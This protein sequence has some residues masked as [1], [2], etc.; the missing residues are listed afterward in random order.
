MM[1]FA[2]RRTIRNEVVGEVGD[3]GRY[4]SNYVTSVSI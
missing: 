4:I 2:C 1:R 3:T